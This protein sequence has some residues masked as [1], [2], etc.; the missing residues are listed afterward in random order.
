MGVRWV[1]LFRAVEQFVDLPYAGR[2]HVRISGQ[3]LGDQ[4]IGLHLI[5][6]VLPLAGQCLHLLRRM[7]RG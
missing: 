2:C 5:E 4:G 1:K 6:H 7:S 3:G